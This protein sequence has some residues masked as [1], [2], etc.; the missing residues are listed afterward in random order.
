MFSVYNPDYNRSVAGVRSLGRKMEKYF[1]KGQTRHH[2]RENVRDGQPMPKAHWH[3]V[4]I[5][6]KR[7]GTQFK[8][9]WSERGTN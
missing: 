8:M 1:H 9:L 4:A 7:G 6:F 3:F 5:G 2:S